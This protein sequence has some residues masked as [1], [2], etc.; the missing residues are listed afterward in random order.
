MWQPD[1]R[2][3]RTS[4]TKVTVQQRISWR[5]FIATEV[6]LRSEPLPRS[7]AKQLRRGGRLQRDTLRTFC[8]YSVNL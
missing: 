8:V 4:R 1:M 5:G 7:F 2:T 3:W 6:K